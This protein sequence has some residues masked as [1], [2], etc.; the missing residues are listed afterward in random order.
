MVKLGKNV[1]KIDGAFIAPS[2]TVAGKVTIAKGASVWYGAVLRG[3]E[4]SIVQFIHAFLILN[5]GLF[6]SR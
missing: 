4:N 1:P 3:S 2:A 6:S 5:I